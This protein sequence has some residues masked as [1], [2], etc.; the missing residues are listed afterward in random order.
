MS[1][2]IQSYALVTLNDRVVPGF[3]GIMR[4]QY[5]QR[6]HL[7]SVNSKSSLLLPRMS[8]RARRSSLLESNE[9]HTD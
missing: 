3:A 6:I 2:Q 4:S 5:E 8:R 7:K 1:S 9:A